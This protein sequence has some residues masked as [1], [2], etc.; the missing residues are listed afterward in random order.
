MEA[1]N[2]YY[3]FRQRTVLARTVVSLTVNECRS[4]HGV[5]FAIGKLQWE[6]NM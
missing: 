2:I 3:H 4:L 1:I 6:I 5:S